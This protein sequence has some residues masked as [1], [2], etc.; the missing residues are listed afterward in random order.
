MADYKIRIKQSAKKELYKLPKKELQ[1]ITDKIL[2]LSVNPRPM[3]VEKLSGDDK[4]RIRQGNYRVIY[5]IR[6][7]QLEITVI[8]I[9]HRKDIYRKP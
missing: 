4:Y 9:G 3:G 7:K 8:R 6:D 1:K 5:L 2:S